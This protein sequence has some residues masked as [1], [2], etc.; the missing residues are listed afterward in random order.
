MDYNPHFIGILSGGCAHVNTF[1]PLILPSDESHAWIL[2]ERI[3]S[4]MQCRKW[5]WW[6]VHKQKNVI[7]TGWRRRVIFD[8]ILYDD[9]ITT[10]WRDKDCLTWTSAAANKLSPHEQRYFCM[11]FFLVYYI[12]H[13]VI[14]FYTLNT[15]T[16]CNNI[17][18]CATAYC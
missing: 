17:S 16:V 15:P 13:I 5:V 4:S 10:N 18:L 8:L 2:Q 9:G 14:M 11:S 6:L 12:F 1:W 7:T 3:W